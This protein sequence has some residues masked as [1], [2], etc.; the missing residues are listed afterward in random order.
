MGVSKK[1][2]QPL[3]AAAKKKA[4]LLDQDRQAAAKAA[5]DAMDA[6]NPPAI[7][8]DPETRYKSVSNISTE[9]FTCARCV[10][11]RFAASER[12]AT[13]RTLENNIGAWV[14]GIRSIVQRP[15]GDTLALAAVRCVSKAPKD[16]PQ[17]MRS[18]DD[19]VKQCPPETAQPLRRLAWAYAAAALSLGIPDVPLQHFSGCLERGA[20]LRRRLAQLF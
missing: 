17:L 3:N 8:E 12:E 11:E 9:P 13:E 20:V 4:R 16:P 6:L 7:D 14:D 5:Q 15:T 1:R 18:V 10:L 19:L 2:P